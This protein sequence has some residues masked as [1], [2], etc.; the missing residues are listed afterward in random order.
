MNK[1]VFIGEV[2]KNA[3]LSKVDARKTV[4]AFIKTVEGAVAKGE[5]VSLLGFGSFSVVK[6]AARRGVNPKTKKPINIAAR[7]V[8]KFKPGAGLAKVVK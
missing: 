1:T 6:K 5:K 7:S 3:G 2:A 4:D 8:V